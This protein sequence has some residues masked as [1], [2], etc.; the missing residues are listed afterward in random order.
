[1]KKIPALIVVCL[2]LLASLVFAYPAPAAR[3]GFSNMNVTTEYSELLK[4]KN[5]RN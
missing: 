4:E 2:L 3:N 1:M 5:A